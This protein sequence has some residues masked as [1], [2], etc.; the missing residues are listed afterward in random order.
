MGR[1]I[2]GPVVGCGEDWIIG[3]DGLGCVFMGVG[4]VCVRP[5][6]GGCMWVGG[7]EWFMGVGGGGCMCVR[8]EVGLG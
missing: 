6:G 8:G 1:L 4:G 5:R 7:L 2:C 3:L